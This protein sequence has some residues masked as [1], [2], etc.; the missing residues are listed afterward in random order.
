MTAL[1]LR[2][3]CTLFTNKTFLAS[4]VLVSF[5]GL[6]QAASYY[7]S[8]AGNDSNPGD[9]NAPFRHL[10]RGAAAAQAG[11][12]VVVMDGTYDNEGQVAQPGGGYVVTLSNSG[13]PGAPI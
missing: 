10:S 5:S 2:S 9:Q 6:A 4:F 13:V 3:L 1:N 11:D 12:T 7:V 8:P